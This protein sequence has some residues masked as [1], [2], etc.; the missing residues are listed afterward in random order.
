[1]DQEL[2]T[3][4]ETD[5]FLVGLLK[6]KMI[7]SKTKSFEFIENDIENSFLLLISLINNILETSFP[8]NNIKLIK[9]PKSFDESKDVDYRSF[10][11]PIGFMLTFQNVNFESYNYGFH[12]SFGD[13]IYNRTQNIINIMVNIDEFIKKWIHLNK[14][15]DAE[16]K[17]AKK[18]NKTVLYIYDEKRI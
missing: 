4:I 17:T 18:Y 9:A 11:K 7:C 5:E 12:K 1:M 13:E 8:N 10:W 16:I 6:M 15:I 2:I 3:Y 14:L